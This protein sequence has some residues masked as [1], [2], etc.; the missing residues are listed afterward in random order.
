MND[1]EDG[2]DE[3]EIT[4]S[5]LTRETAHGNNNPIIVGIGASA[6]G[7]EAFEAFFSHMPAL[8]GMTFVII[9]HLAPQHTSILP[10]LIQRYT[11]MPVKLAQNDM[12]VELNTVYIIPPN[13]LLALFNGKLQVLGPTEDMGVRLP[14]DY[15]FRSL[16]DDMQDRVVGI[17]L[18][19]TGSDGTLGLKAIKEK[20]GIIMVEDPASALYDGM[21]RSA[22]ATGL[23]DFVLPASAMAEK[24]TSYKRLALDAKTNQITP[25]GKLTSEYLQQI[26]FMIRTDT[27]HDFSHYKQSTMRRRIERLMAMN[28]IE[29]IADYARFLQNNTIGIQVLFRDLLIGVTNFFRDKDVFASLQ[30]SV[31]PYLFQNR[32]ANQPI[33]IWVPACSTGEEAYSIAILLREQMTALK[34]EFKVQIFA[35]DIDDQAVNFARIGLYPL[36]IAQDVPPE[37]LHQYF[38]ETSDGYQVVK[39][40]REM[41]VFAQHSVIKDPPFTKLDMISCRNLLIYLDSE[42]QNKVLSYF[43][44]AL[45]NGG[46]LML[47][48]SES[49]GSHEHEFSVVDAAHRLYQSSQNG[50]S[51]RLRVDLSSVIRDLPD[52]R[53]MPEKSLQKTSSTSPG[54]AL[55]DLMENML[56]ND[57][58][59]TCIIINYK[60]H[61]R[62]VHGQ[63]SKYLEITSGSVDQLDIVR[64]ARE[65]LKIPLTTAIYRAVTQQREIFEPGIRLAANGEDTYIN[66]TV[67]PLTEIIENDNLLA[68]F[69]EDIDVPYPLDGAEKE[70]GLITADERE[71]KYRLLQQEL[72]DTRE[73][74]QATIEE[75]KS[76][77][78]EMQSINEELQSTNEELET[79]QEELKAVNEELLTVNTELEENVKE[80]N[81]A[82]NDLSNTF[83]T[84]PTGIILLDMDFHVRRFNPAATQVFKLIAADIGR[85]IAHIFSELDYSTLLQD[86][87][88]VFHSLV[89]YAVDIQNKH[90]DWFALQIRPYRTVQNAIK[91]VVVSFNDITTSKQTEAIQA[92]RVLAENIFNTVRE[93]LLLLDSSLHIVSANNAFFETFHVSAE[94]TVGHHI[95]QLGQGAWRIPVLVDLIK[96]VIQKITTFQD[97]EVIHEFPIIG[98]KKMRINAR[99]IQQI[100]GQPLM[101]LL[102]LE[103]IS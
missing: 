4:A 92:A 73:Y 31:V 43:H 91:G 97:Y 85:P 86:A 35:T 65:S 12:V 64:S 20:G 68:V 29:D 34:Q 93:P 82:N 2:L 47:G 95:T 10:E 6:G 83:N 7:I 58:T 15:F 61:L 1:Q 11:E 94:E 32:R 18:S 41:M 13:A 49:L 66:L 87:E 80:L 63:T 42:L 51:A 21:P 33:R 76:T 22:I 9:Q 48:S 17:I 102:A 70:S 75:L 62:Y 50:S 44:F 39:P 40:L 60:G 28:Q 77:N 55:R 53:G 57:W 96:A 37:Y 99:Q 38:F 45:I 26:L 23:V 16:A 59:P 19:G 81:A 24:L 74:L 88:Q 14:I 36:N 100:D 69:F 89:P 3:T 67:K 71:Q 78:E 72:H 5:S 52:M 79:S 90:G 56:L 103:E 54:V 8:S 101:A 25:H 27:G 46:F 84:I 30:K 98:L